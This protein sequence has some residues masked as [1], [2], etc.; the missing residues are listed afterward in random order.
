MQPGPQKQRGKREPLH[1]LAARGFEVTLVDPEPGDWVDPERL[2]LPGC[3]AA[4]QKQS[5]RQNVP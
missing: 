2:V 5:N 1:A 4:E 3:Q